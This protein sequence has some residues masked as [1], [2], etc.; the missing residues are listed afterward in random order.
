MKKTA[1]RIALMLAAA[2]LFLP[3]PSSAATSLVL[4]DPAPVN[5]QYQQT[6]NSP[7]VIGESSCN[8]PAG[9]VE[10]DI[11]NGSA[12]QAYD[13]SATYNVGQVRNIVGDSFII[14][15]DINT[16]TH[17]LA[18][19]FLDAFNVFINGA[20]A[21]TYDPASPGTQ[22]TVVNNGN[23][24]ADA[25]LCPTGSPAGCTSGMSIAGLSAGLSI[26]FEAIVNSA[27]DGKEQ[28]FLISTTNPPPTV[29]EPASLVLLGSGLLATHR[30]I[31]RRKA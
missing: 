1:F 14:G 26:S 25:L 31:R 18:T 21:Y 17:P 4:V 19:E 23:G 13:L 11:P 8:N 27:T 24:Y 15:I 9:F 6:Q 12:G 22:L 10:T 28:F 16:T 2:A 3:A 5:Q 29:P 7:C 20:L 30:A